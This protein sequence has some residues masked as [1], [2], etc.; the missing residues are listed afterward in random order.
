MVRRRTQEGDDVNSVLFTDESDGN[1][2]AEDYDLSSDDD[3]SS[4][5]SGRGTSAG[6]VGKGKDLDPQLEMRK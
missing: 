6:V 1:T 3:D 4:E 5:E 2:S